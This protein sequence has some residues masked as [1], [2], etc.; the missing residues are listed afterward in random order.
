MRSE[1][2]A[3]MWDVQVL[4][5]EIAHG[6]SSEGRKLAQELLEA[7]VILGV[8]ELMP[9]YLRETNTGRRELLSRLMGMET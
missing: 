9:M 1:I 6:T 2:Y 8:E 3:K 5:G 7:N 4:Q